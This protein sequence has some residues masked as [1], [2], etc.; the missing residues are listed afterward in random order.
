M[1]G[2]L[3]GG[4]G[5]P[6]YSS[7]EYKHLSHR[8]TSPHGDREP[9]VQ[10]SQKCRETGRNP[11]WCAVG[12]EGK[13]PNQGLHFHFQ[14]L[15][16]IS[17]Q[18][19][20]TL[21]DP[22]NR[23]TPGLPVHHQLLESTQTHF[24]WVSDAIQP[25]HPLLSPSPALNLSQHQGLPMRQLFASGGQNIGVSVST[26]VFPMNTQDWS[27][28][29]PRDSQVFSNTTVQKHQF[30]CTQLYSPTLTSIHDH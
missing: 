13:K 6:F 28:C 27:P 18:S 15:Q 30:F 19:C 23:S 20:L 10:N 12:G 4:E 3:W 2:D 25:S 7:V 1:L 29:S 17:A 9:W 5:L 26:S 24:H 21:C 11:Q 14:G 16:F 22:M 8:P